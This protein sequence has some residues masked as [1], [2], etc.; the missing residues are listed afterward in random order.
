VRTA[1]NWGGEHILNMKNVLI[2]GGT[3]YIGRVLLEELRRRRFNVA[4]LSRKKNSKVKGVKSFHWDYEKGILDQNAIEFADVIIHLAGENVS[5]SRWT[6]KQK[7]RIQDSRI[8]TTLLLAEGIKKAVKKPLKF[9]AG[10]AIG[11]YGSVSTE[12]IFTE[13]DKAGND[14]LAKTVVKWEKSIKKIQKLG[15]V[16]SKVRTG[17]VLSRKG[18]A[19]DKLRTPIELG[20]ASPLGDGQQWVSWISVLDLARIFIYL[21]DNNYPGQ[22]FNAVAP[23]HIR[24]KDFMRVLAKGFSKPFFFPKVPAFIMKLTMGEMSTMVLDGSRISSKKLRRSGFE[25]R[26]MSLQD[27][28]ASW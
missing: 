23:Q 28:I 12:K 26:H 15:L 8:K 5:A 7:K 4:V 13:N 16:V 9:L 1:Q 17:L 3:G 10:S 18:G 19:M 21:I 2:T 6:K 22:V 11:Y 27:L 24:N 25:F 20:I 14:F